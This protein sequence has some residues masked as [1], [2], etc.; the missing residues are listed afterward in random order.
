MNET[1]KIIGGIDEAGRGSNIS[2]LVLAALAFREEDQK[3]LPWRG[4]KDSKFLAR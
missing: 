3:K 4:V 1:K 2:P